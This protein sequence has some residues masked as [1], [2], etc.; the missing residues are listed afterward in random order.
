MRQMISVAGEK[1]GPEFRINTYT[2]N[3]QWL[4]A[5]AYDGNNFLVTWASFGQDGSS[6]GI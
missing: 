2:T 4:Q 3:S 6:Y 1:V 5:L